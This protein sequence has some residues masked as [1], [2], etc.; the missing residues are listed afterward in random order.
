MDWPT[1]PR[2]EAEFGKQVDLALRTGE[3]LQER[4]DAFAEWW[5][6]AQAQ[7]G[8]EA[9]AAPMP[10]GWITLGGA[11]LFAVFAGLVAA[12]LRRNRPTAAQRHEER[13]GYLLASPWLLGFCLLLA[14]PIL[15]SLLLSLSLSASSKSLTMA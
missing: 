8:S 4:L 13:A 2:F 14:F 3:P 1:D 6:R 7:A 10:W 12:V 15:L 9:S 11:A 5:A